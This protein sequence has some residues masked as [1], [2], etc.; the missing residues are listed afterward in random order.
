MRQI[1][2]P[3]G[4]RDVFPSDC[5]KKKMLKKRIEGVYESYGYRFIETP[6][7]EYYAS[8]QQVF[9]LIEEEE[10]YKIVDENGKIMALR[11][12]MTLPIARLCATKYRDSQT[13]M[14][15][16]YSA[17]VYKVR[18]AFAGK[19]NEVT[20]CG[21]ELIGLDS[22]ADMEVVACACDVM[23]T[24]RCG[25][26]V[27]EIGDSNFLRL[28]C[29]KA[30]LD[31]EQMQMMALLVDRKEMPR[32]K[33]FVNA[34]DLGEQERGFF[35]H[36]PLM[37]G[38]NALAEAKALCFDDELK[39][40]VERLER[41]GDGLKRLGYDNIAFDLGKAPRL[42]YYTGIIFEAYV[43]NIG[44]AVLSGG[45]YDGMLAKLG[46]DWPACGFGVKL[47]Y[48]LDVLPEEKDATIKLCY[49]KEQVLQALEKARELR[50]EYNVEMVPWDR[51]EMEVE[52]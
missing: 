4:M 48:I 11:T 13:P 19:R 44:T 41:L 32:L 40:I 23:D 50:K 31:K 27:L 34:L 47:D 28:A 24:I 8:Y 10:L 18:Q 9:P 45:R 42:E 17:N 43:E 33:E 3:S 49:P 16:A 38:K 22:H 14:R 30:R 5:I 2:I 1:Q 52:L 26:Y 46:K 39:A 25:R 51:E 37:N 15:F 6:L 35:R 21:V 29:R 36:V 20:D 7:I 12:D